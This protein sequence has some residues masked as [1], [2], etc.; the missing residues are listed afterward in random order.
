VTEIRNAWNTTQQAK[1]LLLGQS[2]L[3]ER[4]VIGITSNHAAIAVSSQ[5]LQIKSFMKVEVKKM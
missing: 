1:R 4:C 2:H 3:V 5:S